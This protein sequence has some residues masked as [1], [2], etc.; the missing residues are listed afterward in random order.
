MFVFMGMG[1]DILK[2]EAALDF[3][4]M[5]LRRTEQREVNG[6]DVAAGQDGA[7]GRNVG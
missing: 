7:R 3:D 6:H 5:R 4:G 2:A 1:D